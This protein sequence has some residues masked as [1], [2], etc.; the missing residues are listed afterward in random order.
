MNN[1][2]QKLLMI[3]GFDKLNKEFTSFVLCD[4]SQYEIIQNAKSGTKTLDLTNLD[5]I[6]TI[7]GHNVDNKILHDVQEYCQLKGLI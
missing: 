3:K 4:N 6:H 7:S 2:L 5:V 1:V